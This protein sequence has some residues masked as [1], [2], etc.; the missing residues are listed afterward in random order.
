MGDPTPLVCDTP[1]MGA[2]SDNNYYGWGSVF[3]TLS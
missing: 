2:M 3:G 1:N